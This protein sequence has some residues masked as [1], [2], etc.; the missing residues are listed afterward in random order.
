MIGTFSLWK[1]IP[2]AR[3]NNCYWE[4]ITSLM[5][6]DI[7]EE[8]HRKVYTLEALNIKSWCTRWEP[9]KM[10]SKFA[11]VVCCTVFIR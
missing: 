4:R 2:F 5:R 9:H 10:L 11:E 8:S 6:K 7:F 3:N 1:F